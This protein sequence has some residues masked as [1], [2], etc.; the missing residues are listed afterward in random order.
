MLQHSP[1]FH[2]KR[3]N[4]AVSAGDHRQPAIR[5]EDHL[6]RLANGDFERIEFAGVIGQA[7]AYLI[8][9]KEDAEL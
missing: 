7:G 5:G 9:L 1:A 2:L 8:S 6:I 3:L 4:T